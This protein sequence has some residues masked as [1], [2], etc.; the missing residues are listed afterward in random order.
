M[1]YALSKFE[2]DIADMMW[3][4]AALD[5]CTIQLDE[6][7]EAIYWN[8]LFKFKDYGIVAFNGPN[9]K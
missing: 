4:F 7:Q 3:T 2:D 8:G 5:P 6:G 1:F 9:W